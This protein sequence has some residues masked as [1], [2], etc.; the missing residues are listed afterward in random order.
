MTD[1]K[2]ELRI[3]VNC[4]LC[5]QKELNVV[6][7]TDSNTQI[8]QCL[9]CGYS[10]GDQLM[11]SIEDN[12]SYKNTDPSLQKFVKEKND[13]IWL[14]SVINL[15]I[16]ILYPKESDNGDM[17]WAFSPIIEIPKGEQ[18]NYPIPENVGEFYKTK[19]DTDNEV[20]F[21]NFKNAIFEI[22]VIA[23]SLSKKNKEDAEV[24]LPTLEKD[25]G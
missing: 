24:K 11:G 15:P 2:E 6:N 22:N 21:D 3:T 19:Y 4:P 1:K 17:Q 14:P 23:S 20:Y 25:N 12:E 10:T 8:M 7:D 5:E 9:G 13:Y 16:G 18:K